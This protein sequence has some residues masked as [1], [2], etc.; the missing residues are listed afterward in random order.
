MKWQ[1]QRKR[2]QTPNEKIAR[3]SHYTRR[4]KKKTTKDKKYTKRNG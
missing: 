4:K 3:N 2:E 1:K